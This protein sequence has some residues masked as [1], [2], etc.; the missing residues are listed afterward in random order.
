M[1][2]P[3]PTPIPLC[4]LCAN[5]LHWTAGGV[6]AWVCPLCDRNVFPSLRKDH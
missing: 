6:G 4:S 5:P 3:D 2:D 1:T